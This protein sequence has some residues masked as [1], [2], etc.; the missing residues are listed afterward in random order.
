MHPGTSDFFLEIYNQ[1]GVHPQRLTIPPASHNVQLPA[2]TASTTIKT[3]FMIISDTYNIIHGDDDERTES[4]HL[5]EADVLF[6][7]GDLTN[8]GSSD[9]Y[10]K[11]LAIPGAL[12]AE[13]KL[14][15]AGNH[16]VDS[17]KHSTRETS[18]DVEPSIKYTQKLLVCH[19]NM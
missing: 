15:I 3:R 8:R 14:R 11:A 16:D 10:K 5:P 12:R 19:T 13:L 18:Q 1:D 2:Y 17:D 6:H 7:C 9:S 4:F